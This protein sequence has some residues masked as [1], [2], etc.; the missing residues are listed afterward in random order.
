MVLGEYLSF[1]WKAF[2]NVSSERF[3][4]TYVKP[5]WKLSEMFLTGRY[6]I[7]CDFYIGLNWNRWFWFRLFEKDRGLKIDYWW[8][9]RPLVSFWIDEMF[10]LILDHENF[11]QKST[12]KPSQEKNFKFAQITSMQIWPNFYFEIPWAYFIKILQIWWISKDF[13]KL[14]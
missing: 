5:V 1:F 6:V 13:A 11:F 12:F 9:I 4:F 7:F 10:N 3:H 2:Q 14:A 8:K